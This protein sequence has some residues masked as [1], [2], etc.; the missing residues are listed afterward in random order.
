ERAAPSGS[1]NSTWSQRRMWRSSGARRPSIAIRAPTPWVAR[2]KCAIA[3]TR[4]AKMYA[5]TP[6]SSYSSV[7]SYGS[8]G[9]ASIRG[10][11]EMKPR[12]WPSL[13]ATRAAAGSGPARATAAAQPRA[14]ALRRRAAHG[15]PRDRPA[16]RRPQPRDPYAG[17]ERQR[18]PTTG[19]AAAR[20]LVRQRARL[21]GTR[22]SL[23]ETGGLRGFD[24][25]ESAPA[26]RADGFTHLLHDE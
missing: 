21:H 8:A 25:S 12:W 23:H 15:D 7:P 6:G 3:C 13:R 20:R 4:C 16:E 19:R 11:E 9:G 14:E 17:E 2:R 22:A 10:P 24:P 5:R 1:L 26:H 18:E